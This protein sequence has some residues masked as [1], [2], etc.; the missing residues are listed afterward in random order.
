MGKKLLTIILC[1]VCVGC[2]GLSWR[3]IKKSGI[4]KKYPDA[5]YLTTDEK[6]MRPIYRQLTTKEKSVYTA[7]YRGISEKKEKIPLP[8]EVDGKTYS[9]I[10]CILEK[11]ESEFYYLDSVYYTAQKVREAKI[12][13]RDMTRP[14]QKEQDL[15]GALEAF[16][17]DV[18]DLTNDESKARYINDFIVR[19]CSYITGDDSEFASTIYGCLVRGEANCEG[20]AKAFNYL[21]AKLGLESVVITGTTDKGENHA[22]NQVN[23]DGE[24]YNI[25]VTWA[26]TDKVGEMRQMYFLC[27]DVEFSKTHYAD[28]SLFTPFPCVSNKWN[29]Y[30]KNGL[31]AD[32]YEKAE[33]IVRRELS[34]GNG[35]IEIRF[36]NSDVY[37]DFRE[38]FITEEN[39][40]KVLDETGY[41]YGN[42]VTFSL[43]EN[44]QELCLTM[45]FTE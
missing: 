19:K 21:A 41:E 3:Y 40:F 11:Q 4:M 30:V 7:L 35:T 25:D 10:Y 28:D 31:Y 34:K 6:N 15:E 33:E 17:S 1:I 5:V 14:H 2:L 12:A 20:Y 18:D 23:I 45:L 27:S 9:R 29:Y 26:D 22:W 37:V 36:A 43:K 8:Y 39:V 38:H 42:E 13:Y 32:S 16:M 44:E 24:W